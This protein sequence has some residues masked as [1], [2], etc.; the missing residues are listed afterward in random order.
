[1]RVRTLRPELGVTDPDVTVVDPPAELVTVTFER[2]SV[3]APSTGFVSVTAVPV[4]LPSGI[5]WNPGSD[6]Q[7]M[8][9]PHRQSATTIKLA[10]LRC[11]PRYG[12]GWREVTPSS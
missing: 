3:L 1:M 7:P 9:A 11:A 5:A 8:R 2:G 4:M 6:E 10:A 12:R